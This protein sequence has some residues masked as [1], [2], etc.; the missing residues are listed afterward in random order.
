M[1]LPRAIEGTDWMSE[2]SATAVSPRIAVSTVRP[3]SSE[4]IV[5]AMLSDPRL[6]EMSLPTTS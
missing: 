2:V 1:S 6:H 3:K 5:R 4:S